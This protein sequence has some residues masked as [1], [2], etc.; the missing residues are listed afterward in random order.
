MMHREATCTPCCKEAGSQLK[1]ISQ[2]A[3][4]TVGKSSFHHSVITKGVT[5][6]WRCRRLGW[7][8]RATSPAIVDM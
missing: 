1:S 6:L 3:C 2:C 8:L 7:E 5:P 4:S